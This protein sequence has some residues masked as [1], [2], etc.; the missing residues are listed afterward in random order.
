MTQYENV[1]YHVVPCIET[2]TKVQNCH[3]IQENDFH[4]GVISDKDK[5]DCLF[6][7][8]IFGVIFHCYCT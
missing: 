8:K 6:F 3:I 2:I 4:V 5:S 7:T 1:K